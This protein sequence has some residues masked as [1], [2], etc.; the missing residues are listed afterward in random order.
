MNLTPTD[1]K[2]FELFS[3]KTL[4]FGCIVSWTDMQWEKQLTEYITQITDEMPMVMHKWEYSKYACP[5]GIDDKF[6]I[7]WHEPQLHDVIN[8]WRP[9]N[10]FISI[11]SEIHELSWKKFDSTRNLIGSWDMRYE[12]D[13]SLIDQKESTKSQL[14]DL[15]TP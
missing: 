9:Q 13:K 1:I 11:D 8:I 10:I 2:L 5:T 12:T 4:S 14:I 7:L 15:F 3:D 6:E